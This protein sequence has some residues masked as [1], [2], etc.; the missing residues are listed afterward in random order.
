MIKINFKKKFEEFCKSKKY[1]RNEK[2][3]E[4]V[5]LLEKFLKSKTKS[6]LFFLSLSF[7]SFKSECFFTNGNK[8][9]LRNLLND[10]L[11]IKLIEPL[12]KGFN[13]LM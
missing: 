5:N 2:Q 10:Y 1:E 13:E 8:T 12:K 3:I 6:L 9:P 11:P 4:I 7:L